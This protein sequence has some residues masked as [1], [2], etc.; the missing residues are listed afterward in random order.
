[1]ANYVFPTV[2]RRSLAL[3]VSLASSSLAAARKL[4]FA[5]QSPEQGFSGLYDT[6]SHAILP[7]LHVRGNYTRWYNKNTQNVCWPLLEL[8]FGRRCRPRASSGL[9]SS[10]PCAYDMENCLGDET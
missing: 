7:H 5:G 10:Q 8:R 1:M 4:Y 2:Q 9:H 3:T 6:Y